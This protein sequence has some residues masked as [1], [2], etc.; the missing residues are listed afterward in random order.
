[1]SQCLSDGACTQGQAECFE[2]HSRLKMSTDSFR[3][4][5][6]NMDIS[7]T[8]KHTPSHDIKNWRNGLGYQ[9]FLKVQTRFFTILGCNLDLTMCQINLE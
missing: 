6:L 7:K 2:Y 4:C 3:K 9:N 1:M 8:G 5:S